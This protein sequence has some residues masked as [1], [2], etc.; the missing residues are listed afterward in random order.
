MDGLK[1]KL[2][3]PLKPLKAESLTEQFVKRFERLILSGE[4]PVGTL[5]LEIVPRFPDVE[6]AGGV[7]GGHMAPMPGSIVKVLVKEGDA[8]KKNDALV[9]MEAMKMEHTVYADGDG[10]VLELRV[11]TGDVVD[12]G[13][14][15]V[16]LD[17]SRK[18]E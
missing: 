3:T 11:K 6:A 1:E 9:V 17:E 14:I 18:S 16:V 2:K 12:A 7:E 10:T 4:A 13:Y 15:L 5:E 8:V